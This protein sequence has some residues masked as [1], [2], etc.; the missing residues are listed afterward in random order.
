MRSTLDES[1][2]VEEF[3]TSNHFRKKSI[4]KSYNSGAPRPPISAAKKLSFTNLKP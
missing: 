3:E 1:P 4:M 2:D